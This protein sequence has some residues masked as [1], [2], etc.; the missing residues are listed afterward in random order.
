MAYDEQLA[1][2]VHEVLVAQ[3]GV[4]Q[5]RMFGGLAFMVNGNMSVGIDRD[6]LMVRVGPE[7]YE[8]ALA[9]PHCQP[10]DI[11]GRPMRGFV[12]VGAAGV[13]TGEELEEWVRMGV[14]F[15]MS[16]PKK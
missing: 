11:T 13:S 10:M 4:V 3:S 8:E 9:R 6:R 16:L 2:R 15:A 12:M 14:Q 1:E 7:G 5:K